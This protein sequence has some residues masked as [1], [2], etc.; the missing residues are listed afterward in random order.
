MSNDVTIGA[1]GIDA[2]AVIESARAAVAGKRSAGIY[3]S[4]GL[5]ENDGKT[6]AMDADSDDEFVASFLENLREAVF[7][8]ISDFEIEEK[9]HRFRG[10][11]LKLK[12]GIWNLLKFYTY[13]L[14]SQQNQVNGLL[15]SSVESVFERQQA[16]IKRLEE[17]IAELEKRK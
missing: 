7:V 11:F 17:R 1:D 13:R 10:F 14:W 5:A 15:L 4:M 3:V 2:D 8:D 9:R 16:E 12:K 6:S